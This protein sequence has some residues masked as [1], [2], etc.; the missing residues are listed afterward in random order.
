M[1]IPLEP[2]NLDL[3][4]VRVV[5]LRDLEF[6]LGVDREALRAL[7]ENWRS[8]YSPF[9]QAKKAKPHQ[10]VIKETKLRDIDNPNKELKRVQKKILT[11]LLLPVKLPHFLFGAVSKR[12]IRKHAE[13]HLGAKTI[14]KMD[15]KK[16]YPNV[17]SKHVFTVWKDVLR[18]STPIARLLTKLTTFNWHLPQGAPTSP[19]LANIF[20][21]S[22]YGPVLDACSDKKVVATSWVDDLIFSGED[23]R[24]VMELVRQTLANK[25]FKLS[26][27]KRTILDGKSSKVIT[28]VRV[29]ATRLRVTKKKLSDV[30]AGIHNIKIGRI[31]ARG[32]TTD[33]ESLKGQI[34]HIK[35]IC[36]DDA[37]PLQAELKRIL[38]EK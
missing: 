17:T 5:S 34:T 10:R 7:A 28:G 22:I 11:Q 19:A 3:D 25:G 8:Q 35:S 15:V 2:K 32:R 18:C 24:S 20:L 36:S 31:T 13:E 12:C 23:A 9:Q 29:G 37:E 6:R 26:R 4:Q 38:G 14:V 33:I 1:N 27:A 30:R 21:A 16:Y